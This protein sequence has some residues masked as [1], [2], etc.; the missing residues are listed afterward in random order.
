MFLFVL[1]V[2]AGEFEKVKASVVALSPDHRI[3]AL[4]IA[5]CFGAFVEGAAGFGTPVAISGALLIGVGFP[6][7]EA[8][9][10]TLIAILT[11]RV[12]LTD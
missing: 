3:Q 2:D 11:I 8:A 7:L 12:D 9:G 10:L 5:F 4:L 6:A 1:T